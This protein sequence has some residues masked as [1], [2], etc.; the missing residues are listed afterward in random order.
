[1]DFIRGIDVSHW[2]GKINWQTVKTAGIQYA[3]LKASEGGF[4]ADDT[5]QFNLE[6]AQKAGILCGPYDFFH[7]AGDKNGRAQARWFLDLIKGGPTD[8]PPALDIETMSANML[9]WIKQWVDEVTE[10]TGRKPIIY[11]GPDIISNHL[12]QFGK[13]PSWLTELVLWLSSPAPRGQ[14]CDGRT[15]FVPAVWPKWKIWQYC[16]EGRLPGI[17]ANVDLDYF[18]GSLAELS[19]LAGGK[20]PAQVAVTS[21]SPDPHSSSTS[22]NPTGTPAGRLNSVKA[23]PETYTV[24]AGDNLTFIAQRFRVPLDELKA[25]NPMENFNLIQIG[26]VLKIPPRQ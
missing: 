20:M 24:A 14:P 23:N 16:W 3:Y 11:T 8:L 5:Y 4:Y 19:E 15:P 7:A 18:N 2:Q 6:N 10:H 21:T 9:G 12:V 17:D 13:V 26:D 1:M 22:S 25:L